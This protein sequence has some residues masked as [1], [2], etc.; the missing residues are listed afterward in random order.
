M[1]EVEFGALEERI[2]ELEAKF[3]PP[4]DSRQQVAETIAAMYEGREGVKTVVLNKDQTGPMGG[5]SDRVTVIFDDG[6]D[7][8]GVNIN[9]YED[10]DPEATVNK[11]LVAAKRSAAL[12]AAVDL[13]PNRVDDVDLR[14]TPK[15]VEAWMDKLPDE[16]TRSTR[17]ARRTPTNL[18]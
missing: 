7:I 4:E 17:S 9:V 8:S 13:L 16:S 11:L 12:R 6:V 14:D 3:E 18:F 10:R 2:T 15:E 1:D 5:K